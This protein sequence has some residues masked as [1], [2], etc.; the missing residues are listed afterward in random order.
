MTVGV[1]GGIN[2]TVV[3]RYSDLASSSKK[4]WKQIVN[5]GLKYTIYKS[6][7][8]NITFHCY[9][10]PE[11]QQ[12][13][14]PDFIYGFGYFDWHPDSISV[15]YNNYSGNRLRWSKK[16]PGTGSFTNGGI[17]ISWSWSW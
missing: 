1:W 10:F 13:W 17:T 16:S 9:P 8:A 15:Q 3:P 6:F 12:P 11:Q 4:E 2:Y 7:Y 5:I 14:D